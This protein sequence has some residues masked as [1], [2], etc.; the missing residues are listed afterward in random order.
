MYVLHPRLVRPFPYIHKTSARGGNPYMATGTLHHSPN[1]LKMD[2]WFADC[3]KSWPTVLVVCGLDGG[4]PHVCVT[5]QACETFPLHP[6]DTCKGWQPIYGHSYLI[7]A[8]PS[9]DYLVICRSCRI[10]AH[11]FIGLWPGWRASPCMD[12]IPDL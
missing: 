5:S 10:L 3:V 12:Y 11:S 7:I 4:Y 9:G 6:Q 8:T 2:W 1:P